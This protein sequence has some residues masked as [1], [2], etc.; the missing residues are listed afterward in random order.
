LAEF[1]AK[2]KTWN[3]NLFQKYLPIISEDDGILSEGINENY[4][5]QYTHL[6][7][8]RKL[9]EIIYA[10]DQDGNTLYGRKDLRKLSN[11]EI[12]STDHSPIIG[13]AYDGNP[14]YGPYGY[15][16]KQG[17]TIAQMKS[18]YKIDLKPNRPSIFSFPQGFFI[19][20]YTHLDVSDQTVLDEN[21]GR[22]CVTPEFPNGTYAYFA[23][24]NDGLADSSGTFSGFKSP[25]FPYFI[26]NNFNEAKNL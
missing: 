26:G 11:K 16:T 3:V 19:E 2:I 25:V 18:G 20:D 24:I 1:S 8:P 4:G 6:Y 7:A 14:I 10:T 23:S 13:W 15:L 22:F 9:R 5:L 17:G 12:T 21:N